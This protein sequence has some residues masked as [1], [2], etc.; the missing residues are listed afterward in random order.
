MCQW[1]IKLQI[2]YIEIVF[3]LYTTYLNDASVK[4]T[5]L[6]RYNIRLL[7]YG[8]KSIKYN[9]ISQLRPS[10]KVLISLHVGVSSENYTKSA[11]IRYNTF[12]NIT[13]HIKSLFLFIKRILPCKCHPQVLSIPPSPWCKIVSNSYNSMFTLDNSLG[14]VFTGKT[15]LTHTALNSHFQQHFELLL[16]LTVHLKHDPLR[17]HLEQGKD[18][19][20]KKKINRNRQ[21][22]TRKK[23]LNKIFSFFTSH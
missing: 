23:F 4:L 20:E 6:F 14:K 5:I 9:L 11:S 18:L 8:A 15:I 22:F 19:L 7:F 1:Q 13:H 12:I 2:I 10:T 16:F 17:R 3:K 21:R